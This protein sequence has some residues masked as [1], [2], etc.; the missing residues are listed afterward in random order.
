MILLSEVVARAQ[1]PTE[2][3]PFGGSLVAA[4]PGF[5]LSLR[6]VEERTRKSPDARSIVETRETQI[7][8][9][10][11]G[12]VRLETRP[13][14]TPAS[15]LRIDIVDPVADFSIY[16]DTTAR[17]AHRLRVPKVSARVAGVIAAVAGPDDE[18]Q[19]LGRRMIQ[20]ITFLGVRITAVPLGAPGTTALL[21]RWISP[22]L[23]LIGL[24][25]NSSSEW[26][27]SAR[28]ENVERKEPDPQLFV[29]PTDYTIQDE[30][31]PRSK[32]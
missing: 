24:I 13:E 4:Q 28:I 9:D 20:G 29:I 23:G 19:M 10:A 31:P 8:R 22:E 3:V 30:V 7:Y 18:P 1:T 12:R 6:Q 11:E 15:P 5:P 25:E 17:I 2:P 27:Y 21:D 16:L 14:G 26:S 32:Q